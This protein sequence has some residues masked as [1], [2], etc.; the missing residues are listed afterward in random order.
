MYI[1]VSLTNLIVAFFRTFASRKKRIA[2]IAFIV[3]VKLWSK[4]DEVYEFGIVLN[5]IYLQRFVY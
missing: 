4:Q 2:T 3:H 5:T 1:V